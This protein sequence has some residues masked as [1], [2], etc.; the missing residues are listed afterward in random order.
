[1]AEIKL[2]IL[3]PD[4]QWRA[5]PSSVQLRVQGFNSTSQPLVAH[6]S[7]TNSV[8]NMS[9]VAVYD[10][11]PVDFLQLEPR[12]RVATWLEN[13][14]PAPPD[15]GLPVA[16]SASESSGLIS[17]HLQIPFQS[18]WYVGHSLLRTLLV[19]T[20]FTIDMFYTSFSDIQSITT[21][22]SKSP[23]PPQLG[24]DQLPSLMNQH[25]ILQGYHPSPGSMFHRQSH[26]SLS[27]PY[28]SNLVARGLRAVSFPRD[29]MN[30]F[31]S[32]ASINTAKNRETCG[33]LL[34]KSKGGR[35][36]VTTLL[37]PKQHAT[38]DTCGIDEE[39]LVTQFMEEQSLITLGWVCH[40]LCWWTR[41]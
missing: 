5:S 41:A 18:T 2:S 19:L 6:R 24:A 9:S 11:V 10:T 32:L 8:A 40:H 17:G 39:E 27:T 20:K 28:R 7:V 37:I 13:C 14:S 25:Q 35:Y 30:S 23:F 22:T 21:T 4:N 26:T 34:G 38:S 3:T 15:S 16:A 31:T 29:C 12:L 1:M 36:V 33:L